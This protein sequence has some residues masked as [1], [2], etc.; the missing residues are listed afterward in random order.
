MYPFGLEIMCAVVAFFRDGNKNLTHFS[1]FPTQP[2]LPRI[3]RKKSPLQPIR[4][5]K[6]TS[7]ASKPKYVIIEERQALNI[8]SLPPFYPQTQQLVVVDVVCCV[9]CFLQATGLVT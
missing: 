3:P 6:R 1:L 5:N 8:F 7:A 9:C 4:S 2:L